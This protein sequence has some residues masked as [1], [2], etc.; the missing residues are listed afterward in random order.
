MKVYILIIGA[1]IIG[2]FCILPVMNKSKDIQVKCRYMAYACGDCYPQ[3]KI[4][5]VLYPTN[6]DK[7]VGEDIYLVYENNS[8]SFLLEEKIDSCWICYD[9]Y[10]EGELKESLFKSHK[11]IIVKKYELKLRS[12]EC[13]ASRSNSYEKK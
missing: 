8:E 13:C 11:K 2:L 12:S 5:S 7:L 6:S 10:V 3:F 9:Y 4:D 1:V